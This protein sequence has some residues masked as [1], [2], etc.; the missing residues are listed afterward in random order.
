MEKQNNNINLSKPNNN[1]SKDFFLDKGIKKNKIKLSPREVILTLL[2]ERNW[3]QT[4]LADKIGI[5]AQGLNNYLRGFWE[6]PTSIKIKIAQAFE[7]DSAVIWDLEE[8]NE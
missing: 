1:E 6:Y 3:K 8:K 5:S 2:R 7:V 4:E